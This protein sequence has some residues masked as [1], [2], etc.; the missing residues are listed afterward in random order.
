[1]RD[2]MEMASGPETLMIAIAPPGAVA[3]AQMVDIY[4]MYKV[5]ACVWEGL[6]SL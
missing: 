1:M 4:I 3:G 6:D 2:V 5:Y